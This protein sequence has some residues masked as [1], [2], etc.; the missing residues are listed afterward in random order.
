MG[1]ASGTDAGG[2]ALI[3]GLVR[4]IPDFPKP[5]IQFR[6]ISPLL[7]SAVGMR[8][9]A[10]MLA[11]PWREAGVTHVLGIEARGFLFAAA[12]ASELEAGVV[13]VRKPGK[14]PGETIRVEY[15][16]EYGSDVIEMHADA[17][18]TGDRVVIIDDVLA[19]GG[20]LRATMDLV[21][22]TGATLAGAGVLIELD[23]LDGRARVGGAPLEALLT[24]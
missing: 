4:T 24:L 22:L 19:T 23:G 11:D 5:G 14:L 2:I 17:I 12:V 21:G 7:A 9:A 6:D 18:G 3:E 1:S 20:T 15:D 13:M 8:T 16:L 10:R